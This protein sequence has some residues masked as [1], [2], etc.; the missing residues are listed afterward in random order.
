[1]GII[2]LEPAAR[3]MAE[4]V[5]DVPDD[6]L[7]RPTPCQEYTLGDLL[8]H[9]GGLTLAF[10]AAA[11]KD[12]GDK[13]TRPPT[14]DASCLA[15][16]WRTRIPHD[17][18]ALAEAWR[19]PAAWTGMTQAGGFE[20]PGEFAGAVVLD[21]LVIHGWDL[22]RATGQPYHADPELLE[23]VEGF[24]TQWF[25]QGESAREGRFGPVVPVPDDAPRLD[26]VLGLCGRDPA[27][28]PD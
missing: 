22:A 25:A 20:L 26:R 10:T 17:L 1:V 4:L 24:L 8:D 12:L 19:D 6:P 13:T 11:R 2:D 16:D 18:E 21:E 7:D 14:A 5:S 28:S 27:W 3:Q 15:P 23:V 9:I